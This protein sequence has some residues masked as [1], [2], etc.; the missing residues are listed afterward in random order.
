MHPTPNC[1]PSWASPSS[2]PTQKSSQERSKLPPFPTLRKTW[3]NCPTTYFH[4][5][6]RHLLF[7]LFLSPWRDSEKGERSPNEPLW[8]RKRRKLHFLPSYP[9]IPGWVNGRRIDKDRNSDTFPKRHICSV[10]SRHAL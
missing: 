5:P 9:S 7:F 2:P 3:W 10:H 6:H 8:K 1:T 4:F